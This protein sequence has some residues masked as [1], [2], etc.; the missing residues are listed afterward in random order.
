V[1][2]RSEGRSLW[3]QLIR[4]GWAAGRSGTS[5][6]VRNVA[7]GCAALAMTLALSAV[8]AVL[9]V[10]DGRDARAA[11]RAPQFTESAKGPDAR[12]LW[13]D[14]FDDVENRDGRRAPSARSLPLAR[15][16]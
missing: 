4:I 1:S 9:A 13:S 7:L 15:A 2:A 10:Y 5:S 16:R 11:A 3:W 8:A 14:K 6:R 12:A